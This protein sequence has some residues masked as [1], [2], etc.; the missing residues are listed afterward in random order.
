MATFAIIAV[1]GSYDNFIAPQV[2]CL[3]AAQRYSEEM[4]SYSQKN[5]ML[6]SKLKLQQLGL[7]KLEAKRAQIQEQIFTF[8][9]AQQFFAGLELIASENNCIVTSLN[10]IDSKT[11]TDDK[12]KAAAAGIL[13]QSAS[14]SIIGDYTSIVRF[15]NQV[16]ARTNKV[17]INPFAISIRNDNSELVECSLVI[18]IY[19]MNDETNKGADPNAR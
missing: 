13:A 2:K 5:K 18:T 19:A 16:M 8:A 12:A 9:A 1:I 3:E 10:Q 6:E 4:S 15:L 14:M 7:N 17:I 11:E